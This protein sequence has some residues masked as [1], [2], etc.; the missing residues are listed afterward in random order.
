[1]NLLFHHKHTYIVDRPIEQVQTRLKWIVTR[2][3][4]DYSMDLVGRIYKNDCF[5]LK[6]KWGFTNITWIDNNAGHIQG[7]LAAAPEGTKIRITTTP[8]KLLVTLFY[9][10]AALLCVV[11]IDVENIIPLA[12]N[13]KIAFLVGVNSILI[14]L[15]ILFR[16]GVRKRFEELMQLA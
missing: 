5:S 3:W 13:L 2:R 1:M 8:N 7:N 11:A 14:L 16:N 12:K 4:E 6:T 9:L 10:A 15:I